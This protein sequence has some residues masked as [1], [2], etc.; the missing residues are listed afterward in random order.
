MKHSQ[1]RKILTAAAGAASARADSADMDR[2]AIS[3]LW[4]AGITIDARD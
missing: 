1:R 2:L 4:G 3:Y